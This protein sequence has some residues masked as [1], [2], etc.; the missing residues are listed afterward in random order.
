MAEKARVQYKDNDDPESWED[1]SPTK[2]LPVTMGD[3][4]SGV[5][6]EGDTDASITGTPIMFE[7]GG[8]TIRAVSDVYPLP[9]DCSE[10]EDV[11]DDNISKSQVLPLKLVLPY[12]FA[13]G[14]DAWI[15]NQCSGDGYL[16]VRPIGIYDAAGHGLDINTDGSLNIQ[17]ITNAIDGVTTGIKTV[18]HEHHEVHEGNFYRSGMNFTLANGEVATFSLT[19]PDTT[20]W[21]H[22]TWSLDTTA[23]GTFTVLEDVTSIAGG[24]AVTPLNHNRNSENTSDMV[25][26]RGMTGSD[27]ITPTGGTTILNATLSTGKG[28]AINVGHG[29]EFILK[30]D[31]IYLFRYTNGTSANVIRLVFEWYEHESVA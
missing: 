30:Q 15:R 29:E 14:E 19:T 26:K 8:D 21:C 1:V 11:D 24:A 22:V 31:S 28:D 17:A 7:G 16:Y 9:V 20:V 13:K 2:P 27:L 12:A 6:T 4:A 23:D 3:E 18:T 5:Y 25:C 10:V